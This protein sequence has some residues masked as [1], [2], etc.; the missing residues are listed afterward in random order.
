VRVDERQI[1]WN[2]EVIDEPELAR[3]AAAHW[4]GRRPH[5]ITVDQSLPDPNDRAAIALSLRVGRLIG[6]KQATLEETLRKLAD[7]SY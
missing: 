1:F 5:I 6:T 7:G 3:R 4:C 2:G